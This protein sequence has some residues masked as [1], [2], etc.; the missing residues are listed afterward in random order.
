MPNLADDGNSAMPAAASTNPARTMRQ[1]TPAARAGA[2]RGRTGPG[3]EQEQQ[4][5]V[6]GH[7]GAD[8]GAMLA[9]RVAHE[10][11]DERAEERAGDAGEESAQAH[12]QALDERRSR[13]RWI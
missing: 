1:A 2:V 3:H 8:G 9:E 6:D 13:Q 12:E 11:R 5:V 4:H 7:D 10:G